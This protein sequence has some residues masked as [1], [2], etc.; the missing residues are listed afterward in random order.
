MR[1]KDLKSIEEIIKYKKKREKSNYKGEHIAP[2]ILI[3]KPSLLIS[4]SFLI[5]ITF[6]FLLI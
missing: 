1:L 3:I 4:L 5:R 6:F 2:I